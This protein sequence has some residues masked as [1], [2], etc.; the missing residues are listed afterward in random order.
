MRFTVKVALLIFF[1]VHSSTH[2]F[3][4]SSSWRQISGEDISVDEYFVS[5]TST[6]VI[7]GYDEGLWKVACRETCHQVLEKY[8]PLQR[9]LKG[10]GYWVKS[11]GTPVSNSETTDGLVGSWDITRKSVGHWDNVT[12]SLTV[13]T[14]G[15]HVLTG[16]PFALLPLGLKDQ[17]PI[18][19]FE[20]QDIQVIEEG[21]LQL[22]YMLYGE[23]AKTEEELWADLPSELFDEIE[24]QI[25]LEIQE[26]DEPKRRDFGRRIP[27]R[28]DETIRFEVTNEKKWE[29][30]ER[31]YPVTP[32]GGV[33]RWFRCFR[34]TY[35]E[36]YGGPIQSVSRT[37]PR[38]ATEFITGRHSIAAGAGFDMEVH[39]LSSHIEPELPMGLVGS[40]SHS[41][42]GKNY[43]CNKDGAYYKLVP[44]FKRKYLPITSYSSNRFIVEPE[45]G[46]FLLFKKNG[47]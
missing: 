35:V 34:T 44:R 6:E 30:Y 27:Q 5:N 47:S 25:A 14:E 11:S 39:H 8:M 16:H 40:S 4:T 20:L 37:G 43:V 29:F 31:G 15:S 26:R 36:N 2:S 41:S 10:V 19:K 24:A 23:I 17:Q 1:L 3:Q 13:S 22:D 18:T 7:W 9:M 21:I 42:I 32:A 46:T 12:A 28:S 38:Y 45:K 33:T